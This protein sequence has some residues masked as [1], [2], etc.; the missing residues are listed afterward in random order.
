MLTALEK[1]VLDAIL[2]RS[3]DPY[4]TL[5][6]QLSYATVSRR[7]FTGV[8]FYTNF[9]V[10]IDAPVRRDLPNTEIGDVSVEL[11]ELKH[12]AG[13]VLFVRDGVIAFLE[14]YTY[15]EDWSDRTDEFSVFRGPRD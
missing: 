1:A 15:D 7:E 12:G 10:P 8:G 14:G 6:R 2:D 5:R 9:A 13:F 11:P 3:G 4:E